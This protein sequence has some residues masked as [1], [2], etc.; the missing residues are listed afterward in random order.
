MNKYANAI[1]GGWQL[2]SIFRYNSGY[3]I[4]NFFDDSGWATNW[5]IKT[6]GFIVDPV[7]TGNNRTN[8]LTARPNLFADPV[9]AYKS[10]RSPLPG[11]TGSRNL[12]RFPSFIT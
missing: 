3:P 9:A 1:L 5:Q 12:L 4:R 8:A 11:D 2:S 6:G 7:E 10:F